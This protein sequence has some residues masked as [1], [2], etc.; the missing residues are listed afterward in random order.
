[1]IDAFKKAYGKHWEDVKNDIYKMGWIKTSLWI[2]L[3]IKLEFTRGGFNYR[4]P[5]CLDGIETNNGWKKIESFQDLPQDEKALYNLTHID[6][7]SFLPSEDF[8]KV[9]KLWE[10]GLITHYQIIQIP[11]PP[12][13]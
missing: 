11:N 12:I 5:V 9:Q 3:G 4:R 10:L 8:F 6:K 13:Y 1:M 7:S 2:K